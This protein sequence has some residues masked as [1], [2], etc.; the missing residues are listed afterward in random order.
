VVTV[1]VGSSAWTSRWTVP[2]SAELA[3]AM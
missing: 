1:A 2:M 3:A